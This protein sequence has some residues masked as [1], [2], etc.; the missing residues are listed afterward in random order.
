MPSAALPVDQWG[1]FMSHRLPVHLLAFV[2]VSAGAWF[3]QERTTSSPAEA[4][5]AVPGHQYNMCSHAGASWTS[6]NNRTAIVN[7]SVW[8]VNSDNAWTFGSAEACFFE[9]Q[10]IASRTSTIRSIP[11]AYGSGGRCGSGQSSGISAFSRGTL[12]PSHRYSTG[13]Y[14]HADGRAFT[15]LAADTFAGPLSSCMTH[16]S[17]NIGIAQ[18]QANEY[19]L[20]ATIFANNHPGGRRIL[21]GDLN[22][23][24]SQLPAVYGSSSMSKGSSGNTHENF[25]GSLVREIDY[26]YMAPRA[27]SVTVGSPL[28]GSDNRS[29]HCYVAGRFH[30]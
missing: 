30:P 17:L 20:Y 6:C 22:L 14:T 7:L 9:M 18:Q 8:L 23:R 16:L 15:C 2:M 12:R 28:C 4:S 25:W 27:S 13:Q 11:V 19:A 21:A 3:M 1:A 5:I 24:P 29:D 26:V 10:D